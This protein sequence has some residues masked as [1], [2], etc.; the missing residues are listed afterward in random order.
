MSDEL[1]NVLCVCL[2]LLFVSFLSALSWRADRRAKVTDDLLR[3]RVERSLRDL[4]DDDEG[5]EWK[6]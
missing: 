3:K 2:L 6:R 4:D 1:A 5:E